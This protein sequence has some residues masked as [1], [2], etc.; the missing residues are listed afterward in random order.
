MRQTWL[1]VNRGGTLF[2]TEEVATVP[3]LLARLGSLTPRQVAL[4]TL[5]AA[6]AIEASTAALRFGA[7]WQSSGQTSWLGELTWGV[8]VHHGYV[9]AVILLLA[10]LGRLPAGWRKLLAIA[11][12]A[13][14]VSDLVHHFLVLWPVTGSPQFDLRYPAGPGPSPPCTVGFAGFPG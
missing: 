10:C 3:R 8:R 11:G 12:G 13:L 1:L 6:A 14:L 7:G 2:R 5:L 4:W 9:G